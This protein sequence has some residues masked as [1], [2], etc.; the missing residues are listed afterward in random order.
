MEQHG[1][2]SEATKRILEAK[3]KRDLE[4]RNKF[5]KFARSD[6]NIGDMLDNYLAWNRLL[7]WGF[8]CK[9]I[10]DVPKNFNPIT[11]YEFLSLSVVFRD[12][13]GM[14]K[15]QVGI[16]AGWHIVADSQY[17]EKRK[18]SDLC[19]R[20]HN[21]S[22]ISGLEVPD[23]IGARWH[24]IDYHSAINVSPK[25]YKSRPIDNH[26]RRPSVYEALFN[27]GFMPT[28]T[29]E[30][31]NTIPYFYLAGIETT[32]LASG[33]K[34]MVPFIHRN[35]KNRLLEFGALPV[36]NP[37]KDWTCVLVRELSSSEY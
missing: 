8:D 7:N 5:I 11:D 21:T 36:N 32:G 12:K 13:V 10:T 15:T 29:S 37:F 6:D 19:L 33:D 2:N 23:I 25:A 3:R 26:G 4:E 28:I 1:D 30:I 24:A 27:M 9:K 35:E 18:R 17:F 34:N 31:G 16:E 14:K 22:I 20:P